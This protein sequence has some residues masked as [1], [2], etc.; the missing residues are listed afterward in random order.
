MTAS[1][2]IFKTLFTPFLALFIS[3]RCF[4]TIKCWRIFFSLNKY[5][6]YL[7]SLSLIIYHQLKNIIGLSTKITYS[8][9]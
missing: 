7:T 2:Y 8:V 5:L 3:K 9:S 1:P 6:Y 4:A